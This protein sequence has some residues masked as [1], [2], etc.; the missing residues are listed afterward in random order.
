MRQRPL[1]ALAPVLLVA[2]ALVVA[3]CG[4]GGKKSAATTAATTAAAP[5]TTAAATTAPTGT[6]SDLSG[7][8]TAANCKQ[9]ADLGAKFSDAVSGTDPQ[10]T[11]KIAQ[12][13]KEF[14]AKTP[15]DIRPDFTLVADVYS[16]LADAIGN[17]QPGSVPDP[18]ILS[19]L[20]KLST[21]VDAEKLATASQHISDWVRTNC[22]P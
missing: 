8:A 14:A 21:E 4:G 12:L 3:G 2:L 16:K 13:L 5:A 10:D 15:T 20:Q 6:T 9:L 11:K 17:L 1:H 22:T 19:K 7:L 18:S